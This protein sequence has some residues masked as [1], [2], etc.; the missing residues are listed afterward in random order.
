MDRISFGKAVNL[1]WFD[2]EDMEYLGKLGS[3][4]VYRANDDGDSVT[5]EVI[6]PNTVRGVR[7]PTYKRVMEIE[8]A[9]LYSKAWHVNISRVDKKYQ[10]KGLSFKIYRFLLSKI[11]GF[12]LQAGTS[13]SPGG[14]YI[15]YKLSQFKDVIIYGRTKSGRPAMMIPNDELREM[16]CY[17][18]SKDAYNSV[19]DFYMFAMKCA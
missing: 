8:L 9:Q 14:A 5:I 6:D 12:I 1:G 3:Y 7:L 18:P 15:W 17:N 19:K 11:P 13:Q 2:L 10:G 4:E 16:Q